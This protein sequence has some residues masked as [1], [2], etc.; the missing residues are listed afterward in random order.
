MTNRKHHI[1]S[2][3][4]RK[5][6]CP[7]EK[8]QVHINVDLNAFCVDCH[9]PVCPACF[10]L[11]HAGH[12]KHD[13]ETVYNKILQQCQKKHTYILETVIPDA[14]KHRNSIS[15]R[16]ENARQE[17]LTLRICMKERADELKKVADAILHVSN[18]DLDKSEMY[19]LHDLE[20]Q[21]NKTDNYIKDLGK[22][23][24]DYENKISSIKMTDLIEL[25]KN[26][27]LAEV[28]MPKPTSETLPTFTPGT[29]NEEEIAKQFGEIEKK[30]F[31][32]TFIK[33]M[34]LAS[35]STMTIEVI[36]PTISEI[37]HLSSLSS[38][39]FWASDYRGNII[40]C[41]LEGNISKRIRINTRDVPGYHTITK[42]GH[43]IYTDT[44]TRAVYSE[45]V[46][47]KLISTGSWIPEAVYSSHINGHT[48][49]GMRREDKKRITRYNKEGRKLLSIQNNSRGQ[50]LYQGIYYITENINGDICTSDNGK[51]VVV[52]KL[53]D[54]RFTYYG[55]RSQSRFDPYGICTDV[56]GHILVCNGSD[57]S[58]ENHSSV[59]LLDQNDQCPYK[60]YALCVDDKHG[61]WVGYWRSATVTVYK[62]LRSTNK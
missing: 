8:C 57:F 36:L 18:K 13:I 1:V 4:A 53:G 45:K 17:I 56:L 3:R 49:V 14:E 43:L 39:T 25:H 48:L 61:L 52:T 58:N 38:N 55:H 6:K 28:R 16:E 54:Y 15:K 12:K 2:F 5:R 30:Y 23:I 42:E 26:M 24:T 19:I 62:Y 35:S 32:E 11:E 22:I 41:D 29:S 10:A 20:K 60:P 21:Q 40:Q 44:L 47:N 46:P 9:I 31:E 50:R 34:K 51:V 27:S 7:S 37:S 59:H 33:T